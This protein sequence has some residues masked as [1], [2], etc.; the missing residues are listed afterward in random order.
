MSLLILPLANIKT[1]TLTIL[2]KTLS[3]L[4]AKLCFPKTNHL[5]LVSPQVKG[6]CMLITIFASE[7]NVL[8]LLS[9]FAKSNNLTPL[10]YIINNIPQPLINFRTIY[11]YK[12][13]S[14]LHTALIDRLQSLLERV[15]ISL[16]SPTSK[17]IYYLSLSIKTPH[18]KLPIPPSV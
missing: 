3:N 13:L 17:L 12:S 11:Q 15:I 5:K 2:K 8:K 7:F 4:P 18:Y 1:N 10:M 16:T 6:Q 9:S 14:T